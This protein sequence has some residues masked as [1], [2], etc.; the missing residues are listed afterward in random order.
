MSYYYKDGEM[1]QFEHKKTA[2]DN[3]FGCGCLAI[4]F[5]ILILPL[6]VLIISYEY[7]KGNNAPL[8]CIFAQ[9]TIT[10]VQIPKTKNK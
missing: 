2:E 9:D 3:T 1:R 10:C 7:V 5:I 6:I 4:I 8:S